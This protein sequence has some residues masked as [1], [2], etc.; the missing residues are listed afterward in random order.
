MSDKQNM[1]EK[2]NMALDALT[3][4]DKQKLKQVI[5][6]GVKILQEIDDLRGGLKD[7]VKG[8]AEQLGVKPK[9]INR[10]MRAAYKADIDVTKDELDTVEEILH[11]TGYR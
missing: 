4:D 1:S 5:S 8:L 9:A 3:S 7:T 2:E 11:V 10:A 6:E